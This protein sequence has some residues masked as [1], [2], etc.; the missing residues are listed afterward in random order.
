MV[1]KV[2]GLGSKQIMF[3]KTAREDNLWLNFISRNK[4][5][6]T[7]KQMS[8]AYHRWLKSKGKYPSRNRV[9]SK[10]NTCSISRKKRCYRSGAK[11]NSVLCTY[12][13]GKTGKYRCVF[14]VR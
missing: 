14:K 2:Y 4:G 3:D 13:K 10:K 7:R 8:N 9:Y 1:K 6:Y 5:K 11:K 12:R